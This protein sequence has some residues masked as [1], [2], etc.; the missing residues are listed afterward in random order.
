MFVHFLPFLGYIGLPQ[1]LCLSTATGHVWIRTVTQ[2]D[3]VS[4]LKCH[5]TVST[6]AINISTSPFLNSPAAYCNVRIKMRTDETDETRYAERREW[7]CL[8]IELSRT[9]VKRM[10]SLGKAP[11]VLNLRT[12]QWRTEGGFGVFK[13]PPR[14]NSEGPS[15]SCQTQ[16]V[17]ENC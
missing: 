16:P 17:C 5:S 10:R 8:C 3:R 4:L 13:P 6:G 15:K 14:R 9:Q 2:S 11:R 12:K 1:P 7:I